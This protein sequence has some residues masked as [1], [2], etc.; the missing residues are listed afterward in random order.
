[1]NLLY[2][3]V[4]VAALKYADAGCY[5]GSIAACNTCGGGCES[6]QCFCINGIDSCVPTTASDCLSQSNDCCPTGYY[7]DVNAI[8]CTDKVICNPSCSDDEMCSAGECVC[9]TTMYK[10]KTI[11]DLKPSV[12]CNSDIMLISIS[13]CLLT[14]LKYDYNTI[15]AGTNTPGCTPQYNTIDNNIRVDHLQAEL[16]SGWCGNKITNDSQKIYF[17]NTLHI[18]VLSSP[19]ITVNPLNFT[20]TCSYNLTMQIALNVTLHPVVG[21]TTI[22]GTNG[23]GAF[24][25]VMA[26]YTDNSYSTPFQES[27]VVTVGTDIYLGIFVTGADGNAFALRVE[28]CV[29]SPTNT[30]VDAPVTI[31]TGGC[32]ASDV[33]T[34]VIQNGQ[35]LEAKVRFSLFKFEVADSVYIFCDVRMCDINNDCIKS[36]TSKSGKSSNTNQVSISLPYDYIGDTSSSVTNSALPWAVLCST[37]LGFLTIKLY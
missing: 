32:A 2:I 31:V 8:C 22:P 7:Y 24:D 6:V 20:F 23:S 4:L 5:N 15:Y 12:V 21:S 29:A 17:T 18:G 28:K 26:A 25:L 11:N 27:D 37:L 1:M 34:D 33:S 10:N 14:Y 9:N 35:T 13:R 3:I 16:N 30:S 19:I 36:C